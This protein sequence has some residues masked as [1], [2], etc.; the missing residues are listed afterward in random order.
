MYTASDH[1]FMI[2]AYGENPDLEKCISSVINQSVLGIV[3]MSTSTPNEYVKSLARKYSLPL[4]V[5]KGR[6]NQMDNLNFAF[7]QAK[8]PLV[9]LCHQ[10]VIYCPNYLENVLQYANRGRNPI[11]IF[12]DYYEIRDG[13][14]VERSKLLMVKRT[15]N[16]PFRFSVL[17]RNKWV[18][19]RIL[20]FGDSIC[21][22]SVTY[23]KSLIIEPPFLDH[24]QATLDWDAWERLSTWDGD[25]IYCSKRLVGN[26]INMRSDT[27]AAIANGM[28]RKEDYE[29]FCRFWPSSVAKII[30]KVYSKAEKNNTI[31]R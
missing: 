29:M 23:N 17:W 30:I 20:S 13:E 1:T 16:F 28:R 10:D 25:F 7:S 14:K 22:P 31:K 21:C 24:F 4:V 5:N 6:G 27:T 19:R 9:T 18:R 26:G 15:L 11:I 8:T 12:T 2:C 3:M